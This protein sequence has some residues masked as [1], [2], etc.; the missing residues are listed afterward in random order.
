MGVGDE[1]LRSQMMESMPIV[2]QI[3]QEFRD[4]VS[5]LLS[6]SLFFHSL[7][8]HCL[9]AGEVDICVCVYCRVP[10]TV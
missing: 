1:A 10:V 9:S 2:D 8:L 7:S 4:P 3:N 6:L 5:Y